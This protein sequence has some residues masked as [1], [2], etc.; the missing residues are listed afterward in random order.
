ML[1]WVWRGPW[2]PPVVID[3][4][5]RLMFRR[6]PG[7]IRKLLRNVRGMRVSFRTSL[8]G[9]PARRLTFAYPDIAH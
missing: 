3:Q 9:S 2:L 1:L 7:R 8:R 5:R 6:T 4:E